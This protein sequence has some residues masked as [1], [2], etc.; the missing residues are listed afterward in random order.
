MLIVG[1]LCSFTRCMSFNRKIN[2]ICLW[3]YA[4]NFSIPSSY[5]LGITWMCRQGKRAGWLSLGLGQV[6]TGHF[7]NEAQKPYNLNKVYWHQIRNLS[8]NLVYIKKKKN[9]CH[10]FKSYHDYQKEKKN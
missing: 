6:K 9:K 8:L 2:G 1:N 4:V 5:S 3:L 7:N 10:K